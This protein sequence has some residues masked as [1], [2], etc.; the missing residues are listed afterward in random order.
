MDGKGSQQ[1]PEHIG[2]FWVYIWELIW[3]D[4][5]EDSEIHAIEAPRTQRILQDLLKSMFKN[6]LPTLLDGAAYCCCIDEEL[7][8]IVC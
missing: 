5:V 1:T 4:M 8:S 2:T 3:S 6:A 7:S